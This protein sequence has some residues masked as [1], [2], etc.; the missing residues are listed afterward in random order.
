MAITVNSAF[1]E[2][3]RDVVNL[4]PDVVSEANK[5]KDNLLENIAE[6]SC[7]NGFF[8]LCADFNI[9]NGSFA[10]K[11][12]CR[13]LDDIDLLIGMHGEG[14]K[15]TA[16]TPWDNVTIN[17]NTANWAQND[18][19]RSDGTL[20]SIQVANRFKKKLE[21]VREYA[22]S[23]IHRNG[24]A[25]VLNLKSKDWSF[26]IVPC[27][28]TLPTDDGRSYY[29]IPNG[30]GNWKKTAPDV[31]RNHVM[32]TNQA[33]EG[34]AL[35]LVRLCKRWNKTKKVTTIP[36]YLLETMIIHYADSV[37]QL[38]KWI[39]YRFRDALG[40]I[41]NHLLQPVDD[42]KGIQG[43]INNLSYSDKTTLVKKAQEDYE[44][45]RIAIN[46]EMNGD[47]KVAISKWGEIF[48][49]DF[50]KYG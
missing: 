8:R 19:S 35:P 38:N 49:K 37:A 28:H 23:E 31:D 12:K 11:T 43:D 14:A 9:Q 39:D 27:F 40:Y 46:C 17:A 18:C 2:F 33:K 44:R 29:L 47:Q 48:G 13:E 34:R 3:M 41:A 1:D 21:S 22:R 25:I 6:F 5:S 50:P 20:D 7:D 36:S 4:D 30:E 10:R 26:D 32:N 42:L 16:N 24:E 45:A 15:Y